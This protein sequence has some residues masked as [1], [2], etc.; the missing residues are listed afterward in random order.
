MS[1]NKTSFGNIWTK[2]MKIISKDEMFVAT[3]IIKQSYTL[4]T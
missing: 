2:F 1:G 4:P 3:V